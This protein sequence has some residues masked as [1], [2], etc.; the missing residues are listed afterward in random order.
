[1]GL[2]LENKILTFCNFCRS[3]PKVHVIIVLKAFQTISAIYETHMV[4]WVFTL[5][6]NTETFY[7]NK[8]IPLLQCQEPESKGENLAYSS[9]LI[10][11]L[12][13]KCQLQLLTYTHIYFFDNHSVT[14][15]RI[16][17]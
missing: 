16:S 8:Q 5:S 1:M 4:R 2:L 3:I 17:K 6:I 9:L 7:R 15:P 10:F 12:F 11:Y 13:N 14:S